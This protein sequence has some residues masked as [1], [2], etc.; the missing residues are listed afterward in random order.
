VVVKKAGPMVARGSYRVS[1]TLYQS[2]QPVTAAE[3]V[4]VS[5][6][7]DSRTFTGGCGALGFG[8]TLLLT[9][10][11]VDLNSSLVFELHQQKFGLAGEGRGSRVEHG[12]F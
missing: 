5:A 9:G 8:C 7:T 2:Y 6:S 1:A 12:G 3:G 4:A 10:V 11:H